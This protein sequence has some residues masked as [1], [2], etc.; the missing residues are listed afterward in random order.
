MRLAAVL[1]LLI[2][3]MFSASVSGVNTAHSAPPEQVSSA[4]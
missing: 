4:Y 1:L 2:F 3:A